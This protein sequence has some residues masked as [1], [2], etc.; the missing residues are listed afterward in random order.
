MTDAKK[1]TVKPAK[2][3]K[4]KG[5]KKAALKPTKK[6]PDKLER[7]RKKRA[8]LQTR[9]ARLEHRIKT[10][11]R[12]NDTR[13]KIIIGAAVLDYAK[14]EPDFLERLSQ[15]LDAAVLKDRDKELIRDFRKE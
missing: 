14:I 6:R 3:P 2:K 4:K 1:K 5:V 8:A 9:I 7:L 12:Q 13:R 10:R 15:I 11:D